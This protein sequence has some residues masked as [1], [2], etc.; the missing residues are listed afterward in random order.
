ME[1]DLEPM[2]Q[3]PQFCNILNKLF[4]LD[5]LDQEDHQI[6]L[7]QMGQGVRDHLDQEVHLIIILD[8]MGQGDLAFWGQLQLI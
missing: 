3:T 7:D 6:M 2:L 1:L 5:L 4:H 8:Q